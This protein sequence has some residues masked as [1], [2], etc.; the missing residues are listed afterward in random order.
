MTT[1]AFINTAFFCFFGPKIKKFWGIIK[2]LKI[3]KKKFVC[4]NIIIIHS[5]NLIWLKYQQFDINKK[6]NG[7]TLNKIQ[8]RKLFSAAK[9]RRILA[10]NK[11]IKYLP[12]F[13]SMIN[14][15][16][17]DVQT[18]NRLDLNEILF[19]LNKAVAFVKPESK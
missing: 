13:Y 6:P 7:I 12:A 9:N 18:L 17:N 16:N 3:S 15:H 5:K 10:I 4:A 1:N 11:S 8:I 19:I 14:Y 2:A